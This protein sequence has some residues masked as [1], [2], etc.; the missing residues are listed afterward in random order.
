MRHPWPPVAD[1]AADALGELKP[2]DALTAFATSWSSPIHALPS[3]IRSRNAWSS[4]SWSVSTILHNC[5]LCHA[6]SSVAGDGLV[7]G[8][9]PVPGRPLMQAYYAGSDGGSDN[10]VRADTT[11]LRQDFS[12]NLKV[13]KER[14]WPDVQCFDFVVRLRPA[15]AEEIAKAQEG[16]QDYPQRRPSWGLAPSRERTV[17][18]SSGRWRELI[19][20]TAKEDEPWNSY[21]SRSSC[22]VFGLVGYVI[23]THKNRLLEGFLWGFLLGPFGRTII[24]LSE[25]HYA[26]K[27]PECP[28]RYTQKG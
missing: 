27:C 26:R 7:C 12:A 21:A 10:F 20:I 5:L 25:V 24:A 23:G 8:L 4:P 28:F 15:T 3:A 18:D 11:F 13:E 2:K 19:G 6:P 14:Y 22:A 1:H 17:A 9:V 16:S